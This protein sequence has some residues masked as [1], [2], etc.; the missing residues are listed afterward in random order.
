MK[1]HIEATDGDIGHVQSLLVDEET[2]AIRYM[3]VDTNNWW[4]GHQVLVAPQW[5]REVR[6]AD[7]TVSVTLTRQAVKDA[8]QYD[9]AVPL[10]RDR[11]ADLYRHH[12]RPSYWADEVNLENPEFRVAGL[13]RRG[14]STRQARA[15]RKT[16]VMA[17]DPALW[18]VRS[19]TAIFGRE[20]RFIWGCAGPEEVVGVPRALW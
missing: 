10:S 1:Y 2:W 18:A 6:W 14:L 4:L 16:S 20:R 8:P 15:R 7:S 3:V 12:G 17:F 13:S 9:A 19:G 11:E 5:I